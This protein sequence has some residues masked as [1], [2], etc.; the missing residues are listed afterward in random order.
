MEHSTRCLT[1]SLRWTRAL[2]AAVGRYPL[3]TRT[4]R[5]GFWRSYLSYCWKR[6]E[7]S[8]GLRDRR[9][10]HIPTFTCGTVL[11]AE[12]SLKYSTSWTA[13]TFNSSGCY[14]D[15]THAWNCS[16]YGG[17]RVIGLKCGRNKCQHFIQPFY[18]CCRYLREEQRIRV[19]ENRVLME[20]F[21]PKR[22]EVTGEWRKL[23]CDELHIL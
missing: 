23:H 3:T 1:P 15:I 2:F 13:L 6:H 20:I 11:K 18:K 21:G 8:S 10:S 9:T 22:D 17:L 12:L 7:R 4:R 19:F 14:S 16:A 5:V